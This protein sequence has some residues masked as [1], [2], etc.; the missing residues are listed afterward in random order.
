LKEPKKSYLIIIS[1]AI[2]A[3]FVL[4]QP[5][6]GQPIKSSAPKVKKT[7]IIDYR[8][9]LN[10]KFKKESRRSTAY[11][12]VHTSEA[13]LL[14]TLRT[15]SSGKRV[16]KRRRT[17]GGH[18]H[19]T[20]ARNGDIYRILNHAYRADHA[21]LSMWNGMTDLSSHS[22]GIEL[23]GFHYDKITDE[24]Y[25]SLGW[26]VKE[27]QRIYSISDK[28]VLAHSQ[29]SY[30]E[31]NL[32]FKKNHRGRK[33]CA[34]N[35]DRREIGLKSSWTY[36][37]DVKAG[38][39]TK[40]TQVE[41]MFYLGGHRVLAKKQ[42]NGHISNIIGKNNTAW[43]IAGEDYD[44]PS[45]LYILPGKL[46]NTIRG[47]KVAK[48]LGWGRL[49]SGTQVLVNQP[50]GREKKEGPIFT[51]TRDYTAWSFAGSAYRHTSTIYFLPGDKIL[52]G[53][54]IHDWDSLPDGT[55]L[56]IGYHGPFL[57]RAK[58]GQTAWG[59]AKKAYNNKDTIYLIPGK[60]LVTG[61]KITDF[62]DFPPGTTLFLKINN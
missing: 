38:R 21:G 9:H 11:I 51:I 55:R 62:S 24:Q 14:S 20:I 54:R 4:I 61:D 27:L 47:D 50:K 58:E 59:F 26:L 16:S 12:I 2:V 3:S 40:D 30:G 29:V 60:S 28:N 22:L 19:Y 42:G 17:R 8:K 41:K 18:A 31:P 36:D 25:R 7:K 37:P 48:K 6:L 23:V 1:L 15:L 52:P 10:R 39:L 43:N 53:N 32:W 49:P 44:D 34:L 13:G 46:K 5:C 56:I 57:I 45:T 33:R 35:F